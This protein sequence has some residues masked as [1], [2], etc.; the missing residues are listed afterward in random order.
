[1]GRKKITVEE[2]NKEFELLGIEF[3]NYDGSNEPVTLRLQDGTLKKYA[4]ATKAI[5][6]YRIKKPLNE[7]SAVE[8]YRE[9][10]LSPYGA[11][12]NI[13]TFEKIIKEYGNVINLRKFAYGTKL[14]LGSA[15]AIL[16]N[17]R[18]E[19]KFSLEYQFINNVY[20]LIYKTV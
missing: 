6:Y 4:R 10:I 9:K 5:E 3:L 7:N 20:Q 17:H 16:D 14:P 1:M 2:L 13:P 19:G 8:K 12:K 15:S 11:S 18:R